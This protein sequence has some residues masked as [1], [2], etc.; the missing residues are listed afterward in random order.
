MTNCVC[1]IYHNTCHMLKTSP[2]S[3]WKALAIFKLL[4]PASIANHSLWISL[5]F[6]PIESTAEPATEWVPAQHSLREPSAFRDR[7]AALPQELSSGTGMLMLVLVLENCI[8]LLELS[9]LHTMW[10]SIP[11]VWPQPEDLPS[12]SKSRRYQALFS[13]LNQDI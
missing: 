10:V 5:L 9:P 1:F 11:W 7:S 2:K 13:R 4:V 6:F 3:L 8:V 12:K